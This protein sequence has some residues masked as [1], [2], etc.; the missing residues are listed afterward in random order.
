MKSIIKKILKEYVELEEAKIRDLLSFDDSYEGNIARQIK[1]HTDSEFEEDKPL[2]TF[3]TFNRRFN[4]KKIRGVIDW[5]NTSK[6][7]LYKRIKERTSFLNISEF[8]EVFKSAMNYIFPD[9]IGGVIRNNGRYGL[10]LKEYNITII[11]N[12]NFKNVLKG[13]IKINVIT[14]LPGHSHNPN[15]VLDFFEF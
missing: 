6:H 4:N 1:T 14:V 10:Y 7:N 12:V 15:L 5:F 2:I 9:S 13:E 8:N 11:F 3:V